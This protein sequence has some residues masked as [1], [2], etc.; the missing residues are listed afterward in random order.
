M[1]LYDE[2]GFPSGSMGAINGDDTP[3]FMQR[4]PDATIKR[5]DKTEYQL[6]AGAPCRIEL[7]S[8]GKLMSLVAMEA[9]SKQ[10]IPLS[11]KVTDG[12]LEWNVPAEGQ[13]TVLCFMCVK[14]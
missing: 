8:E 13:W 3:R 4:H 12:M 14:D 5:L 10:I 7:P 6:T 1:S 2:Y 11:D 9:A